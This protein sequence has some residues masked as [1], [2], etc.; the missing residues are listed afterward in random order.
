MIVYFIA[1][2]TLFFD[3][4]ATLTLFFDTTIRADLEAVRH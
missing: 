4:T 3:T 2:L 1:A